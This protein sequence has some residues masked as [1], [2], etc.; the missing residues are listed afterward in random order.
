MTR[1]TKRKVSTAI[2]YTLL[3][4]VGFIMV[5]PL[6]WMVGAT[7]KTNSEIYQCMVPA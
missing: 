5:Y 4:L 6:I 1:E 3:I 2:R 7:F